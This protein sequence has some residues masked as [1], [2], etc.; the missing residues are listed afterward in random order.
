MIIDVTRL[1]ELIKARDEAWDRL[2]AAEVEVRKA[3]EAHRRACD[4]MDNERRRVWELI[5]TKERKP[6]ERELEAKLG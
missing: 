2:Q 5:D 4:V 1:Q 6:Y 3:S